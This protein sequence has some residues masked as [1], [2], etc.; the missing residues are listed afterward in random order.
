MANE[1]LTTASIQIKKAII[2]KL[3]GS[4][5]IDLLR[6]DY[7]DEPFKDLYLTESMF[8]TI[9][10]NG[11]FLFIDKHNYGEEF[12]FEGNEVLELELETPLSEY[13]TDEF[14]INY[15]SQEYG[16]LDTSYRKMSLTLYINEASV[17]SDDTSPE[18]DS[19]GGGPHIVWNLGLTSFESTIQTATSYPFPDTEFIGKIAD[20]DG[21][22]L[23]NYLGEQYFSPKPNRTAKEDI[24][25]EETLNSIWFKGWNILYPWSKKSETLSILRLMNYL[26]ENSVS[27][28]N[29]N[30]VNYL[31]WQDLIGWHFRSVDSILKANKGKELPQFNVSNDPLAKSNLTSLLQTKVIDQAELF[32]SNAYKSFYIKEYPSYRDPYSLYMPTHSKLIKKKVSYDYEKEYNNWT[33]VEDKQVLPDTLKYKDNDPNKITDD[34]TYG[35]FDFKEYNDQHPTIFDQYKS[36]TYKNSDH[37]FQATFDQTDLD[38]EKL[39]KIKNEIIQPSRA[40]FA[41]YVLKRLLKEKWNVYKYSICCDE[42]PNII[43]AEVKT[44]FGYLTSA[45]RQSVELPFNIQNESTNG[46]TYSVNIWKYEWFPVEI[47]H[48]DEVDKDVVES[49]EFEYTIYDRDPFYIIRTTTGITP[50]V[51]W[52]VNELM[53]QTSHYGPGYRLFSYN[54]PFWTPNFG[55]PSGEEGEED[56]TEDPLGEFAPGTKSIFYNPIGGYYY[57]DTFAGM[58]GEDTSLAFPGQSG[59]INFA[60][61]PQCALQYPGQLV[62]MFSVFKDD[63][64][65]FGLTGATGASGPS[66]LI[67]LFN[68]QNSTQSFCEPCFFGS[69]EPVPQ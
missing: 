10:I 30:A 42:Q 26:S 61:V 8:S 11:S 16:L 36:G 55:Q 54:D 38:A 67:Y 31:F 24:D 17:V 22:G 52:N 50:D 45:T 7:S 18:L 28:K 12:R 6:H 65:V 32:Q 49:E 46:I 29:S 27:G 21:K 37:V 41:K 47:W 25:V 33:H 66:E 63:L 19:P 69:M 14:D 39:R 53:N 23:V 68:E 60:V 40:S 35:Y 4:K 57:P 64:S 1:D 3:D 59:S 5:E 20:K 2:R 34:G 44:Q 56:N 58:G 51:A 43:Q 62:E 9:G 13:D 15:E 48:K